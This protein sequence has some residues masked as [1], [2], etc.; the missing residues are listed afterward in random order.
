MGEGGQRWHPVSYPL[1]RGHHSL[2]Q[3]AAKLGMMKAQ[4]APEFA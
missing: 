3:R 1:C 4:F 2:L